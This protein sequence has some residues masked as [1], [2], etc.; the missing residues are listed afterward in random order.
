MTNATFSFSFN[1]TT[2]EQYMAERAAWKANYKALTIAQRE[3]KLE[4][5]KAFRADD[6]STS[7][8]LIGQV[9]FNKFRAREQLDALAAA[10]V[11]AQTQYLAAQSEKLAA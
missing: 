8:R 7:G 6:Y 1:F 9:A 3:A 4:L 11:E 2:R 5:K 10:K